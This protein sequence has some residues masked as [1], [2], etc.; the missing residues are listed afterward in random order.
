MR[1]VLCFM[2]VLAA[3]LSSGVIR[4]ESPREIWPQT[5]AAIDSGDF[6][7][8]NTKL[9][10]LF[11]SGR[12]SA[13]RRYP[14]Y[15]E[16]AAALAQNAARTRNEPLFKWAK[17]AA[18]RLDPDSAE[19][20]FRLAEVSR[21]RGDW[22]GMA[23]NLATGFRRIFSEY[24]PSLLASTNLLT[25]IVL[26]LAVTIGIFSIVLFFRYA[27][28]A[29]HDFR[30]ALNSRFRP[31]MS[32]V[33]AF[34]LLF[35][36]LFLWLGPAWLVL[37]WLLLF[38]PY[39]SS[40]EK[41][42]SFVSLSLLALLPLAL[43]WTAYRAAGVDSPIVRGASAGLSRS[44][45]PESLRRLRDLTSLVPDQPLLHLL[46]GN[47]EAQDGNDSESMVHLRR[48][49]ELNPKLAGAYL[50][51]GNLHFLDGDFQAASNQYKKAA[52]SDSGLA[53]AFYNQSVA[54]GELY[55]FDEQGAQI[56]LAKKINRSA[57]E[58]L[59]SSPPPQK[60]VWYT[61][62]MDA[63]W[64][65]SH[66]IAR[67]RTAR[68]IFGNFAQFNP[69]NSISN[70]LTAGALAAILAGPLLMARRR[71]R[72][73][74]G[75][76]I[77]CGRTFC[78]RCKSSRESATY[79]TQCIHIYLKRDGVSLDTKRAKLIEVQQHQNNLTRTRK[80][81]ATLIPGTGQ[82][83]DSSTVKG[84]ILT[85]LFVLAVSGA[86]LVGRM[87]PMVGPTPAMVLTVRVLA[88]V[89]VV[90]LWISASLSLL[91]QKVTG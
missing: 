55:K 48:A 88:I 44:Y 51:Q 67:T 87:A 42:V 54:S 18:L 58:N 73:I 63:A 11:E 28:P 30:E 38:L 4:A 69:L 23:S 89:V 77:K 81:L 7:A 80:T 52:E 1:A 13:V 53:I 76:C 9:K 43:D 5:T 84:L 36:P 40:T 78:N 66:T 35:L 72:G 75:S 82:M 71:K 86:I 83:Y 21:T 47:L 56:E 15:A 12:S 24:T 91:R 90:I 37:Y 74:A 32:S 85:L 3:M 39:S 25:L 50:N 49:T 2:L 10:A 29:A 68:D 57:I 62:P 31:G 14:L 70:P 46:V 19:V 6:A 61:V 79:C 60:I 8:A 20:A 27:S 59:I 17:D 22:G 33:L 45:D 41:V 34:A 65:L 64:E 26:A 16:S